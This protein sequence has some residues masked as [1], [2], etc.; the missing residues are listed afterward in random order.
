[1]FWS[2]VLD[3]VILVLPGPDLSLGSDSRSLLMIRWRLAVI[4]LAIWL[5]GAIL[6]QSSRLSPLSSLS[7]PMVPNDYRT[8]R[9]DS[10]YIYDIATSIVNT[11]VHGIR[12]VSQI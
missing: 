5:G 7:R 10:E 2:F 12:I 1:M 4:A 3:T 9:K 6:E 11:A 8:S